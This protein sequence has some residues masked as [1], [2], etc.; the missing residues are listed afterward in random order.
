MLGNVI[1]RNIRKH[2]KK[3]NDRTIK[4]VSGRYAAIWITAGIKHY[5]VSNS[6]KKKS[7]VSCNLSLFLDRYAGFHHW[8]KFASLT[9]R[10]SNT[11]KIWTNICGSNLISIFQIKRESVCLRCS[12]GQNVLH[13]VL[14]RSEQLNIILLCRAQPVWQ[15]SVHRDYHKGT[16]IDDRVTIFLFTQ[17]L[18]DTYFF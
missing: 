5:D 10:G 1:E 6:L 4:P 13:C 18:I 14:E 3:I 8:T 11:K 15:K 12:S 7:T 17:T 2:F 9:K 16:S